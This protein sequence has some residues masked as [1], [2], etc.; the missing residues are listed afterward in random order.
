MHSGPLF[1][2]RAGDHPGPSGGAYGGSAHWAELYRAGKLNVLAL[3]LD[4]R[5]PR[6]PDIP[7]FKESGYDLS[8]LLG[9]Y[10]V[11]APANTPNA[12]V[13]H[14]AEAL[15]KGVAEKGYSDAMDNLGCTAR[16][17]GPADSLKTMDKLDRLVKD[18]VK[19][20]NLKPE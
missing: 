1:R 15:K 13:N 5:D 10:W 17:E 11:A 2:R 14:L 6:F 8:G 19:K 4:Q 20:Y 3:T 12:I 7:T 18:V 9:Y 16:W